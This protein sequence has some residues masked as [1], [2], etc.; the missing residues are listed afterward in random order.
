ME[1]CR[2]QTREEWRLDGVSLAMNGCERPRQKT[3]ASPPASPIQVD[4]TNALHFLARPPCLHRRGCWPPIHRSQTLAQEARGEGWH[5]DA[6]QQRW[7]SLIL[8][9]KNR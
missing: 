5:R 2:P 1:R 9:M 6:V 7:R 4:G 8:Q 3:K